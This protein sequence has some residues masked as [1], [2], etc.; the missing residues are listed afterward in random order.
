M[1]KRNYRRQGTIWTGLGS[2]TTNFGLLGIEVIGVHRG[3]EQAMVARDH[4]YAAVGDVV[5]LAVSLGVVA[6]DR[7]LRHVHIAVDDGLAD[8]AAASHVHMR[9]QDAVLDLAVGVDA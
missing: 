3:F 4:G 2:S 1:E 8:L 9:E 7:S 5:L 6:D